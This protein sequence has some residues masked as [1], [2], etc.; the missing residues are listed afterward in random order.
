MARPWTRLGA[1][2]MVPAIIEVVFFGLSCATL[3]QR[4]GVRIDPE[5][6]DLRTIGPGASVIV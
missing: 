6:M 5:R 2:G 3:R 4:D 1:F